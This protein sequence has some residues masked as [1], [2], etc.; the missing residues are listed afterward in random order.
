MNDRLGKTNRVV[1]VLLLWTTAVVSSLAAADDGR[2]IEGSF[3]L[4]CDGSADNLLGV[5]LDGSPVPIGLYGVASGSAADL[6]VSSL[7]PVEKLGWHYFSPGVLP[8]RLA[9]RGLRFFALTTA[10]D[11]LGMMAAVLPDLCDELTAFFTD[12]ITRKYELKTEEVPLG[13]NGAGLFTSIQRWSSRG[14]HNILACGA[15]SYLLY[16]DGNRM[17]TWHEDLRREG[18][19]RAE[20][21]RL[22]LI[23]E[24]TRLLPDDRNR[25]YGAFGLLFNRAVEGHEALRKGTTVRWQGATLLP[26]YDK[27][28]YEVVLDPRLPCANRRKFSGYGLRNAESCARSTVW[29][30]VKVDTDARHAQ[31]YR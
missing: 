24:A 5:S 8:P 23:A 10:T 13:A 17:Y 11:E 26:P 25:V 7:P 9:D 14:R 18:R 19:R 20:T 2:V 30:A 21:K 27:A 6:D 12:S 3:G 15:M 29:C 1:G 22:E 31:G 28:R 16:T 4:E